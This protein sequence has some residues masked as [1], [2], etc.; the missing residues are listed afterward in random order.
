MG[1][2]VG[3]IKLTH[4]DKVSPCRD[5]DKVAHGEKAVEQTKVGTSCAL[6]LLLM[7]ANE[8]LLLKTANE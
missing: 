1:N 2:G 3:G 8:I 6:I 7:T 5:K 4:A